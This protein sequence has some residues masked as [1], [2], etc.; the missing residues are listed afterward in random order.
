MFATNELTIIGLSIAAAPVL[1]RFLLWT[2]QKHKEHDAEIV[3]AAKRETERA[4]AERSNRQFVVSMATNH[5][6]H[7]FNSDKKLAEGV[8]LLLAHNGI[9]YRV[10]IDDAPPINFVPFDPNQEETIDSYQTR[11]KPQ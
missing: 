11:E 8:N 3:A 10:E 4:I 1:A 6:P 5:L 2:I 7:L 9:D